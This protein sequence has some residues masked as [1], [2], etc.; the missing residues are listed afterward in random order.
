MST[1]DPSQRAFESAKRDFREKL[2]DEKLFQD[3]LRTR[4]IDEVWKAAKELQVKPHAE[5]R[6]RN[7]GKIGGFLDKLEGYA[8]TV[9][10]FVQVKP[11]ILALIWGPIH[12]LMVWTGNITQFAD[13]IS[14]VMMK[15]GDALPRF[16]EASK[17][18]RDTRKLEEVLALF[19]RDILDV[20]IIALEFFNLPR[21][22]RL[23]S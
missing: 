6:L 8:S 15:V 21:K 13:A 22:L 10:K 12:L 2:K 14:S 5:R 20:Y 7:L 1:S 19:Y 11:E 9:D 16:V 17:I 23:L 4:S 3:I 18:F